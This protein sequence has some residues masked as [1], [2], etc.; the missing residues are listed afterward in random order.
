MPDCIQL[1]AEVGLKTF[2]KDKINLWMATQISKAP[3]LLGF[4]LIIDRNI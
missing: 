2:E 3:F 4:F 1:P